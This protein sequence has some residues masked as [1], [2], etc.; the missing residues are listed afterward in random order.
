[1]SLVQVACC[2]M[3]IV[4]FQ[5]GVLGAA[6]STNIVYIGNMV[7]QDFW[8]SLHSE[9]QFKNMWISWGRSSLDGLGTYLEYSIPNAMMDLFYLLSLELFVCLSGY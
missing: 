9:G 5:W 7:L 3:F 8:I 6:L 1:M 4:Q 2:Y